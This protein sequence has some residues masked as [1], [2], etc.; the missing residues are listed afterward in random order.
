M[1]ISILSTIGLSSLAVSLIM[2]ASQV[3]SGDFMNKDKRKE[4][5]LISKKSKEIR[6][7][8]E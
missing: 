8:E 7:K 3:L 2:F 5:L 6:S 1:L 4:Y